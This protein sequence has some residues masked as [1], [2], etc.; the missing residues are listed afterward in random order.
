[1]DI[2]GGSNDGLNDIQKVEEEYTWIYVE[3][4]MMGRTISRKLKRNTLESCVVSVG[5]CGSE[6]VAQRNQEAAAN[7]EDQTYYGRIL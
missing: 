1:M 5:A 2:C 7:E 4:V 3:G 6:T